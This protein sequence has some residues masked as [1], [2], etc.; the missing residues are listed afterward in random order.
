MEPES[1][2]VSLA[3]CLG[4]SLKLILLLRKGFDMSNDSLS[5]IDPRAEVESEIDAMFAGAFAELLGNTT[6]C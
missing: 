2:A 6:N 3:G 5:E 1:A 4:Q